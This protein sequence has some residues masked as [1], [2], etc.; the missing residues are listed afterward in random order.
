MSLPA[1]L[2][3]LSDLELSFLLVLLRLQISGFSCSVFFASGQV[4][5]QGTPPSQPTFAV[6][7]R[8]GQPPRNM[9]ISLLGNYIAGTIRLIWMRCAT[10]VMEGIYVV[11][12]IRS[13]LFLK[14]VFEGLNECRANGTGSLF[15]FGILDE[16]IAGDQF[17]SEMFKAV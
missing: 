5:G 10:H 7:L 3:I 12:Q 17:N 15:K 13:T 2:G 16:L 9:G 1:Q 14:T 11:S 8:G 4:C 6:R